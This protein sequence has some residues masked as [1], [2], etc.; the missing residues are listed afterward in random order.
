MGDWIIQVVRSILTGKQ[1]VLQ[2]QRRNPKNPLRLGVQGGPSLQAGCSRPLVR[3]C[4]NESVAAQGRGDVPPRGEI[5]RQAEQ[6]ER[7]FLAERR[8]SRLE[9]PRRPFPSLP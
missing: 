3:P 1:S 7:G 5:V 4:A 8:Q 6:A 2:A 9:R